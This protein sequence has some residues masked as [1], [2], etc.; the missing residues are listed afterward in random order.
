MQCSYPPAPTALD[1][2]GLGNIQPAV[3]PVMLGRM[4]LQIKGNTDGRAGGGKEKR[5]RCS[6]A[7]CLIMYLGGG[8][9]MKKKGGAKSQQ[10]HSQTHLRRI[11]SLG[12]SA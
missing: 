7:G 8:G 9:E 4:V 3:P 1:T 2:V 12:P 5:E 6:P 10:I 11:A